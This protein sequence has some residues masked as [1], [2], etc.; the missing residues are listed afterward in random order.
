M[1]DGVSSD[2][3]QQFDRAL[4]EYLRYN[5][6]ETGPLIE[7]RAKKIQWE[8]YRNFKAIAPSRDKIEQEAAARGY[9]IRRRM[10]QDGKRFIPAANARGRHEKRSRAATPPLRGEGANEND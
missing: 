5:R 10:G 3:L 6:R 2:S 4:E 1:A 9:A 7:N 8:L